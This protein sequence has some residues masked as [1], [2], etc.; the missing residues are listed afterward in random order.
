MTTNN[1]QETIEPNKYFDFENIG[2][3]PTEVTINKEDNPMATIETVMLPIK[4]PDEIKDNNYQ[5]DTEQA[6]I[7]YV[8]S[9]NNKLEVATIFV[10]WE[11]GRSI[12]SFYQGKYGTHELEK[13]S[14][15]TGIGR[16]NLNKMIKFAVQYNQ[17]Q[18]KALI[19]KSFTIPW[20]GIAQ[21]LAIKPEKLIEVYERAND[22]TEF[23]NGIMKCK[24]PGEMRGKSRLPKSDEARAMDVENSM[25]SNADSPEIRVTVIPNAVDV[26]NTEILVQQNEEYKKEIERL[27]AENGELNSEISMLKNQ[28]DY[29]SNMMK[30]DASDQ[31]K[32]IEEYK[33]RLKQLKLMIDKS[34][35]VKQIMEL[36]RDVK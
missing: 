20:N 24:D 26:T 18:L 16:D 36:L 15:A 33:D 30:E 1:L 29:L 25:Q 14:D 3:G 23:H 13:I 32:I 5:P 9:Q 21:N 11:I 34:C 35:T 6:L 7:D 31:E 12:N 27:K 2:F 19:N 22:I 28:M 4:M 17:E 10:K 8:I